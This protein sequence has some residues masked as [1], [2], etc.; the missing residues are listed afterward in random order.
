M[1]AAPDATAIATAVTTVIPPPPTATTI[2][3]VVVGAAPN[4]AEI[5]AAVAHAIPAPAAPTSENTFCKACKRPVSNYKV[6]QKLTQWMSWHQSTVA[7]GHENMVVKVFYPIYAPTDV[8]LFSEQ[9]KFLFS[10]F[11]VTFSNL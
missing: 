2:A 3:T 9:K 8:E 4:S 5:A 7:T 10:V 6:L 1:P 11:L